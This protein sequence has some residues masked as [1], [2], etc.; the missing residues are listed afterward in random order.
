MTSPADE[1]VGRR[2]KAEHADRDAAYQ[3][4][5]DR[6]EAWNPEA[7]GWILTREAEQA[8]AW[9]FTFEPATADLSSS[10]AKLDP[11]GGTP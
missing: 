8:D 11:E 2:P 1:Y 7:A 6:M 3:A 9:W 10:S 4:A 5:R